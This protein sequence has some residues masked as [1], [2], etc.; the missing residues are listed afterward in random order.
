VELSVTRA[1]DGDLRT[2]RFT[3]RDDWLAAERERLLE[4]FEKQLA[5][6]NTH[7]DVSVGSHVVQT[8]D[9]YDGRGA[10]GFREEVDEYLEKKAPERWFAMVVARSITRGLAPLRL[11][12]V[13]P[14]ERNFEAVEVSLTIPG[15]ALPYPSLEE[16]RVHFAPP[17]PPNPWGQGRNYREL[18]A[19]LLN[20]ASGGTTTP[21]PFTSFIQRDESGARVRF[22]STHIR[23]GDPVALPPIHLVLPSKLAGRSLSVGWRVTSTSADAWQEG[24]ILYD[25]DS[26]PVDIDLPH[27]SK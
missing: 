25:I 11:Q 10:Q 19:D 4:P 1:D 24:R 5:T 14:T 6:G 27:P 20:A 3:K 7:R 8:T 16:A 21:G 15:G 9:P 13:N 23:P 22:P 18:A 26:E 17:D 12:I 2:G